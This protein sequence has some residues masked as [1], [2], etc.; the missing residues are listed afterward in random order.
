[1]PKW[2]L[3]PDT[4]PLSGHG[5]WLLPKM[6]LLGS[7]EISHSAGSLKAASDW[8]AICHALARDMSYREFRDT[9]LIRN[10]PPPGITMGP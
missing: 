2:D 4:P 3:S 6:K 7:V 10:T 9:S 1:M 8:H 5:V